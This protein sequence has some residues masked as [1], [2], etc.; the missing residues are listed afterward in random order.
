MNLQHEPSHPP[1]F[2][3]KVALVTGSAS[4]LGSAAVRLFAARGA[5]VVICDLRD[6]D[7]ERLAAELR[8]SGQSAQFLALDVASEDGW[9]RVAQTVTA[10]LGALHILVNNAGIIA[11]QGIMEA[12]LD[13][14]HRVM[15]VN[16]TGAFLGSRQLA[17]LIRDSGGGAIVNVSSTAGL[18]AH[19][20]V[21]Y[22]ASKWALRGLTKAIAL[23]LVHWNIRVNSV[24]PATIATA[25]TDAAPIGHLEA[26]RRAIPMGREA[27]ADEVAEVILFLASDRSSFMTGAELAVDGGL[28][29]AGVAWMRGQIQAESVDRYATHAKP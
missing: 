26:N 24:H 27:S 15:D 5:S 28:S 11:R 17:P 14:W 22:T 21:A 29:T 1:D 16:V 10:Q 6:H 7:G 13:D 25:L 19:Q 8:A 12:T 20:D 23:D 3:N 18:I 9:R 2:R 4:G